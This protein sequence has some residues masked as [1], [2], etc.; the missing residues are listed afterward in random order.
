[1]TDPYVDGWIAVRDTFTRAIADNEAI[2]KADHSEAS[3]KRTRGILDALRRSA[4]VVNKDIQ[5]QLRVN[6]VELVEGDTDG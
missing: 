4:T 3:Q 1:M 5:T 6:D 2:L